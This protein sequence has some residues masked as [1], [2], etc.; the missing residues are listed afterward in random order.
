MAKRTSPSDARHVT[1]ADDLEDI[2][3]DKRAGWRATGAK[4]RRRQRRYQNLL[5]THL[6]RQGAADDTSGAMSDDTI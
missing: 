3:H 4:A 2:V 6:I 1:V 5:T